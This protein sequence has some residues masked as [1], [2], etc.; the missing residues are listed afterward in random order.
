MAKDVDSEHERL[1]AEER[2]RDMRGIVSEGD[3]EVDIGDENKD[4][5]SDREVRQVGRVVGGEVLL[6]FDFNERDL[7]ER[8][9]YGS[10]PGGQAT[11]KTR[12]CVWLQHMPTGTIVKCHQ[13]RSL[14]ENRMIARKIMKRK[15]ESLKFGKDSYLGRKQE[16]VRRRKDRLKRKHQKKMAEKLAQQSTENV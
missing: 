15:L 6:T 5:E 3:C 13:T 10:G 8:F 16:R 7:D 12:N 11:N 9:V 14:F 2:R 4:W 1:I